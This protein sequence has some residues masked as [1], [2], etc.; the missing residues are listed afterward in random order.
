[1]EDR[2]TTIIW[3]PSPLDNR[4]PDLRCCR[5]SVPVPGMRHQQGQCSRRVVVR[6]TQDGQEYGFCRVHDPVAV[7]VRR[8]AKL[9]LERERDAA[10]TEARVVARTERLWEILARR[11]LGFYQEGEDHALIIRREDLLLAVRESLQ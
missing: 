3:L 6:R 10:R 4:G 9:K 5:A 7:A 2:V 1:M 11:P 8:A